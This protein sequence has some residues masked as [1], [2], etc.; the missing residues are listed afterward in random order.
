M[1]RAGE[2]QREV[3]RAVFEYATE[4]GVAPSVRDVVRMT[5]VSSTSVAGYHLQ[6]LEDAGYLRRL[7]G[8]ARGLLL[9]P[10]AYEAMREEAGGHDDADGGG[11]R[12]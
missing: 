5:G 12:A 10:L 4:H 6:R 11:G 1:T 8:I 2:T 3:L 7:P 9:E